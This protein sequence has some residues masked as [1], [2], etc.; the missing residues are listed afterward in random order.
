MSFLLVGSG[1][2]Y[3][4]GEASANKDA[5]L[6]VDVLRGIGMLEFSLSPCINLLIEALV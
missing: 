3:A 6:S 4:N 1:R 5:S 2:R